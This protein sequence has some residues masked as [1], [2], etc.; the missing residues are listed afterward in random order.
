MRQLMLACARLAC[1][2]LLL[3]G[4]AR[5]Q[6]TD[7]VRARG[8]VVGVLPR[9][10]AV[11]AARRYNAA[12]ARRVV[13]PAAV[14]AGEIVRG[15]VAVL[16]GPLEVI[17]R[18]EG[19]VVVLNGDVTLAPTAH[20]TG[21]VLVVGGALRRAPEAFVGGELVARPEA[22]AYHAEGELVVVD[23]DVTAEER[24]SR[25]RRRRDGGA[26]RIRL[27]SARTYN[28]VEGLPILLGPSLRRDT[29]FGGV[30]LDAFGIVRTA[31]GFDWDAEDLGHTLRADVRVGDA[32]GLTIG[33]RLY[34]VVEPTQEW[35][36]TDAEVGLAAFFLHR[37]FRDYFARHG[38]AGALAV[39]TSRSTSVGLA[40]AGER[41]VSRATND[42]WT[43]FRNDASWRPNPAMD[44][45]FVHLVTASLRVDTRNDPENPW[46]GWLV[47][48]DLESGRGDFHTLAP[49]D[50]AARTLTGPAALRW[51]RGLLD[52]RR[53]NR[54]S[55][56]A[57]LNFR[58]VA[59][60]WLGG[61]ELPLQRRFSL[62]GPG[63]LPGFDFRSGEDA[64]R[65][66]C[67]VGTTLPGAPGQ[68]ERV[69][70]AQIEYRGVIEIGPFEGVRGP[71]AWGLDADADWILFA[72][73]GRGW[74]VGE[75]AAALRYPGGRLPPLSTFQTDI[76]AGLDLGLLGVYVA[77]SLSDGD[78]PPNLFVR[79]RHRF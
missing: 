28:R 55:P 72:D 34:D 71:A 10:V 19:S 54:L 42:P 27:A 6:G 5:A 22:L 66:L 53:Y 25:W 2:L 47:T 69:L 12:A 21:D 60:G 59:G 17:G 48:A 7:T 56:E 49:A 20:V 30:E 78:E 70:L 32:Y 26:P 44:E 79:I 38:G 1:A 16:G 77:K 11:E 24:W 73:A 75:R 57:Q 15:D 51:R 46:S 39:R 8:D 67:S 3:P 45:G 76:G 62:G 40:Y 52:L 14:G 13:G 63:S 74:L 37:D 50:P 33:G 35:E 31:N 9:E 68:C 43:L 29:G 4:A 58:L 18:V 41:W 64:E 23:A 65:L 61:D 36:L